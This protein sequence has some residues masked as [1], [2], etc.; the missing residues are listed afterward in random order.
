[1]CPT[2]TYIPKQV[3]YAFKPN[4]VIPH[5]L[6]LEDPQGQVVQIPIKLTQD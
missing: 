5:T 3:S 1:M 2:M 4:F 6:L